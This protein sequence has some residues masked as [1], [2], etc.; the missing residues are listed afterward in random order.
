MV[1]KLRRFIQFNL[2]ICVNQVCENRTPNHS[3]LSFAQPRWM[4]ICYTM[5]NLSNCMPY[6]TG[7]TRA[8]ELINTHGFV[9]IELIFMIWTHDHNSQLIYCLTNQLNDIKIFS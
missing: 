2:K 1:D 5:M 8:V 7:S 3:Y 9:E 6:I 4:M